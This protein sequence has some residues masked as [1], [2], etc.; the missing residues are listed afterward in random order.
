MARGVK[1]HSPYF[2]PIADFALSV[3]RTFEENL[4]LHHVILDNQRSMTLHTHVNQL[5]V[6]KV[7]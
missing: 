2:L 6:I 7:M 4:I 3:I 1:L 5:L